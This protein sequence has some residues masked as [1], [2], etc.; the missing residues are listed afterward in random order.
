MDRTYLMRSS[1]PNMAADEIALGYK[2]LLRVG[3]GCRDM[4][5]A[6]DLRPVYHRKEERIR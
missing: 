4:K 3:R 2:R 5:S 1:D 6:L